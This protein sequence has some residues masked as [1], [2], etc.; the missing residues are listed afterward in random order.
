MRL[1]LEF[2]SYLSCELD[3]FVHSENYI[4]QRLKRKKDNS[5]IATFVLK[6]SLNEPRAVNGVGKAEDPVT[7]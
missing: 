3:R 4:G 1:A 7:T 6:E 5:Q 2:R